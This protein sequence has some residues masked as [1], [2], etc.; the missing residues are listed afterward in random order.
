MTYWK[1]WKT[2]SMLCLLRVCL[3]CHLHLSLALLWCKDWP[4]NRASQQTDQTT[5]LNQPTTHTFKQ[6]GISI[7]YNVREWISVE[8]LTTHKKKNTDIHSKRYWSCS[9]LLE[10]NIVTIL[11]YECIGYKVILHC[12]VY[13]YNIA[14]LSTNIEIMDFLVFKAARTTSNSKCVAPS[15]KITNRP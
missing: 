14:S 6:N 10:M 7:Q 9:Y 12:R 3:P 11:G 8:P 4:T 1:S 15:I 13:L 2:I 5:N